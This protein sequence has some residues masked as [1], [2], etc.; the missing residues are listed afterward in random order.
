MNENINVV[1][2]NMEYGIHEQVTKNHDDSYTIIL[3][4]RDSHEMQLQSYLHA[5]NCHI[6]H[7]DFSKHNVQEIEIEAHNERRSVCHSL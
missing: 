4:A 1:L 2:L 6:K 7:D 5:L 3:N